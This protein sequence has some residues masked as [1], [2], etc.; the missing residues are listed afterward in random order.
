[1]VATRPLARSVAGTL[2]ARSICDSNQPPKMSP[3][4]FA[5]PG[6]AMVLKA[7]SPDGGTST[8]DSL[9]FM[10]MLRFVRGGSGAACLGPER[11]YSAGHGG[12]IRFDRPQIRRLL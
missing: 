10:G 7:A 8:A 4:G 1:M 5:S 12:P 9:G 3:D 11:P 2:P 6:I